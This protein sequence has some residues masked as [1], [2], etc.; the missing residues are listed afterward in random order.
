MP[1]GSADCRILLAGVTAGCSQ[2][3]LSRATAGDVAG[4]EAKSR[5]L[6]APPPT[7]PLCVLTQLT[8]GISSSGCTNEQTSGWCYVAHGSCAADAGQTC[9]QNI[10]TTD[11]FGAE[12]VISTSAWLACP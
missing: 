3:G 11:A 7:G 4:V 5:A 12:K 8:A 2:E 9:K 10:C 6:G 1:N